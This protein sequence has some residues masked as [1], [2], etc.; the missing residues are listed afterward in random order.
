MLAR[1]DAKMLLDFHDK[2]FLDD[3]L[4]MVAVDMEATMRAHVIVAFVYVLDLMA[5]ASDRALSSDRARKRAT[6]SSSDR[7]NERH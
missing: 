1:Q 5:G 7:A 6:E 2:A 3:S 4:R